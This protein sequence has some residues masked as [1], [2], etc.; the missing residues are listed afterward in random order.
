MKKLSALL[1]AGGLAA[2]AG[3]AQY[4][5][6]PYTR[7]V[8]PSKDA[9]A[10]L[11][12]DQAWFVRVPTDGPRDGIES[13][14]HLGPQIIVQTRRG[15]IVSLEP[16]TGATQW[17]AA[18]GNPYHVTHEV[19]YNDQLILATAGTRVYGL[20]R[21]SG[22][23]A[24]VTDL[25][26]TPS[27]PPAADADGFYVCLS[28]G[29]LAAYAFPLELGKPAAVKPGTVMTDIA[30]GKAPPAPPPLSDQ[31]VGGYGFNTGRTATGNEALYHRR[32][33]IGSVADIGKRPPLGQIDIKRNER[34]QLVV[35]GPKLRWEYATHRRI[36]DRP[37]LSSTSV[38]VVSTERYAIV[39]D[40]RR[41]E[42]AFELPASGEISAPVGSY[43]EIGYVADREGTVYCY[44]L[45][46]TAVRW[47]YS[48]KST[49]TIRTKP[50]ATDEDLY[51]NADNGGLIRLDRVT[52]VPHWQAPDAFRYLASNR[53]Y[54]YAVDKHEKLLVLDRARGTVLARYDTSTFPIPVANDMTDR[55]LLAAEDGSIVC[56]HDRAYPTPMTLRAAEPKVAQT[57]ELVKKPA[58]K[59][60]PQPADRPAGTPAE[61]PESRPAPEPTAKAGPKPKAT[62]KPKTVPKPKP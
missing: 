11:N 59:D 46:A 61:P 22:E 30:R 7:P 4:P 50:R 6:D 39:V 29:R 34:G 16:K 3:L 20:D 8:P 53:K 41:G 9:L 57:A 55:V 32:A 2:G 24:W 43:G 49:S 37:L 23:Q 26:S 54:V 15:D 27:S 12:L 58:V 5:N 19:G 56:L 13:V 14:Q 21:A 25:P 36:E 45:A 1:V 38:L 60:V 40:K 17:R 44:D 42:K 47:T 62:P 18:I 35:A 28:N 31:K 10:R 33:A 51:I 52:G 48:T